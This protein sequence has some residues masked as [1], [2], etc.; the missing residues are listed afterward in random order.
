MPASFLPRLV[1]KPSQ[2]PG[3]FVPFSFQ[4]RA[5]IFDLGDISSLSPRD[6]LK[7]S[8]VFVS[9]THMDHFIGFDHLLRLSLGRTKKINLYGPAG[10][11]QNLEG[12]LAGYSWDLVGN[13]ENEL[14]L[15]AT[16]IHPAHLLTQNYIC[17]NAFQPTA[18]P[19]KKELCS[20]ILSKSDFSVSAIILDHSI[21]CLGFVLK[22]RFHVNIKNTALE[23]LGLT[24]GPWLHEFKQAL[25][26][27]KPAESIVEIPAE[28]TSQN[29]R[30]FTLRELSRQIAKIT[31]GEKIGYITDVRY[32]PENVEKI[33]PFVQGVDRL[34]IEAAFLDAH[35]DTA[36]TKNHLTARQ[37]GE[38]CGRAGAKNFTIF[39]FSPRYSENE[40]LLYQEAEDAYQKAFP[41]TAPP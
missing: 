6:I 22:E 41:I 30:L 40:T 2:D 17:Q 39:H 23:D 26:E 18:P 7:I 14:I 1:N 10:F 9:H 29:D 15:E 4:K 16:E 20:T 3:L 27:N 13:Y 33:I 5:I 37:A 34:F 31:P 36:Y 28:Q 21:P 8:H 25:F 11:I 35:A 32:T 24:P 38:I 12:K 19:R